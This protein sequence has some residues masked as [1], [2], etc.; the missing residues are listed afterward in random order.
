MGPVERILRDGR[1][2]ISDEKA[3]TTGRNARDSEGKAVPYSSPRAAC[4][5]SAGALLKASPPEDDGLFI[6]AH[7]L[8]EWAIWRPHL[9]WKG[10]TGHISVVG[11]N[12][13]HA[14]AEVLAKWDEAIGQAAAQ[15]V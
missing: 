5:C 1:A 11:Y 3:W 10:G 12:D 14:H 4:W 13:T 7:R 6:A 15:G 8:L 2:L 9:Q